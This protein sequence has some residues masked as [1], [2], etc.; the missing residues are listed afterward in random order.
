M[1]RS[2]RGPRLALR[3]SFSFS[4]S[5]SFSPPE[6]DF[7]PALLG[8][9]IRPPIRLCVTPPNFRALRPTYSL[10]ATSNAAELTRGERR[11]PTKLLHVLSFLGKAA[12]LA[13]TIAGPL[14]GTPIG[15]TVFAAA[16]LLKDAVNHFG[17]LA[18]D[19]KPNDSFKP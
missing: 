13:I 15:L 2:P 16:S 17:D 4:Y 1:G 3:Q 10:L 18:D 8:A 6:S 12:G 7:R 5:Y 11:M 19:G 9:L 14:S